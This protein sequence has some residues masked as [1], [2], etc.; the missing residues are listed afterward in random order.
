[1]PGCRKIASRLYFS[2]SA[3]CFTYLHLSGCWNDSKR[4]HKNNLISPTS[5]GSKLSQQTGK[6]RNVRVVLCSKHFY[7][8]PGCKCLYLLKRR[9]VLFFTGTP[10]R[11]RKVGVWASISFLTFS[12]TRVCVEI[13][14]HLSPCRRTPL[15][16][17]WMDFLQVF[18]LVQTNRSVILPFIVN[19]S[20]Y[21]Q[22]ANY[23]TGC[24]SPPLTKPSRIPCCD[25]PVNHCQSRSVTNSDASAF[26]KHLLSI[27]IIIVSE[28]LLRASQSQP[29][30]PCSA[31]LFSCSFS[32][33]NMHHHN[34]NT[35]RIFGC[36][37]Q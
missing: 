5:L 17:T 33:S 23:L 34:L 3:C 36:Y 31:T 1:M 21:R 11:C 10:L 35:H 32:S 19:P 15:Y 2:A 27:T 9:D 6:E 20:P 18:H 28:R 8:C 16:S 22:S 25:N 26:H 29:I 12:M 14:V 37:I 4:S 13:S 30:P 24:L 7:A